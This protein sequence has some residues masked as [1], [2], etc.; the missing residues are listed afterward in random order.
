MLKQ[1]SIQLLAVCILTLTAAGA[2]ELPILSG[3]G[4]NFSAIS[5]DGKTLQLS[6]LQGHV[7]LLAFGYTNCADICPFTLG[8]LKRVYQSLIPEQKKQVRIIF[9]T[10][11]PDYDTPQHLKAYMAHFSPDFVGLTGSREQI[12]R[13][14]SLYQA[15]YQTLADTKLPT[16]HIRRPVQKETRQQ[17]RDT[18]TL[19]S[20]SI[21]I[22]LIDK[23]GY[24]R[25][26]AFTGTPKA[27][28]VAD[29]KA[30]MNES[31]R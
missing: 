1:T 20:H 16:Q 13:I 9:V 12:D 10:V 28:L 25:G 5:T 26:L 27:Q 11:D 2:R 15:T 24:T 30:L 8:Y 21:Q 23:R 17:A 3:I 4:G 7:V 18:T 22:F 31:H 29:M 14:V 6:Q 19:Y